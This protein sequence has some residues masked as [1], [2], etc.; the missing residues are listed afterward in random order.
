MVWDYV[1]V[2]C[3]TILSEKNGQQ[4]WLSDIYII[5]LNFQNII[6]N[7]LGN[8]IHHLYEE[9]F[10][11]FFFFGE[12]SSVYCK[13]IFLCKIF[14]GLTFDM[15]CLTFSSCAARAVFISVIAEF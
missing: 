13:E 6:I 9:I 7:T 15:N 3:Q 12:P 8:I 11:I 2:E 1:I 14:K 4:N 10:L 5:L